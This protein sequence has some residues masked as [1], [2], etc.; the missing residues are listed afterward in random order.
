M[1]HSHRLK[2]EVSKNIFNQNLIQKHVGIKWWERILLWFRKPYFGYDYG[3]HDESVV[4]IAKK[5][6][7]KIYIIGEH[8]IDNLKKGG[9]SSQN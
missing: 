5:L 8:H 2:P 3:Y 1:T 7:G 4:V 9:N 6:F